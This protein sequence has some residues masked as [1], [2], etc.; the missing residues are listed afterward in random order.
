METRTFYGDECSITIDGER[1][2]L[3]E[4]DTV[5]VTPSETRFTQK[6]SGDGREIVRVKQ[7]PTDGSVEFDVAR[8]SPADKALG[9]ARAR[10]LNN[11]SH[12]LF[13]EVT[14]VTDRRLAQGRGWI[15]GA[16]GGRGARNT[17]RISV[18][19]L[20]LEE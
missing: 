17:W 14:D 10:V 9:L 5:R 12:A 16:P 11:Q 8:G 2:A 15:Q 6:V 18:P 3:R 19:T 7:S 20:V 1:L 4:S 13:L